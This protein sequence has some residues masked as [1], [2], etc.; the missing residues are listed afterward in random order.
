MGQSLGSKF[1][2]G[3]QPGTI[4]SQG[5]GD[6]IWGLG[7]PQWCADVA[8]WEGAR[9]GS[10]QPVRGGTAARPSS[11][12]TASYGSRA[13]AGGPVHPAVVRACVRARVHM[14]ALKRALSS[15]Q[16]CHPWLRPPS[17]GLAARSK[18]T[19]GA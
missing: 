2:S 4:V 12:H 16:P 18:S 13:L 6:T 9:S 19:S 17:P 11:P 1:Q 14:H 5:I 3:G 15:L 10:P 7:A 8:P